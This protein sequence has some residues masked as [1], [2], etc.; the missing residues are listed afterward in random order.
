MQVVIPVFQG[1][2]GF[3][4]FKLGGIN[5]SKQNTMRKIKIL[6]L[7]G[8][9]ISFS[10]NAQTFRIDTSEISFQNKLRACLYV[11]YDAEARAVKKAWNNFLKK[12]YDIK[13]KG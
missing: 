12:N 4:I 2:P 11:K 3:A 1:A 5:Q 6:L 13:M 9:L 10:I 8:A 7:V